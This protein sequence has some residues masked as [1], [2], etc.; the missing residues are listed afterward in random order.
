[1]HDTLLNINGKPEYEAIR[2]GRGFRPTVDIFWCILY[3]NIAGIKVWWEYTKARRESRT[4]EYFLFLFGVRLCVRERIYLNIQ[5]LFV[6]A[7][8]LQL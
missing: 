4:E 7:M 2:H 3:K 6:K 5:T 8:A 1:M